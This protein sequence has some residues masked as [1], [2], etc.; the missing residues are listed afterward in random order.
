VSREEN[1]AR[2]APLSIGFAC[3]SKRISEE[4]GLEFENMRSTGRCG[5]TFLAS[6]AR[7]S[8]TEELPVCQYS[9]KKVS[10]YLSPA[11]LTTKISTKRLTNYQG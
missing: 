5:Q 4:N 3:R 6:L 2:I 8:Q 1:Y 10:F 7:G 9:R 11:E